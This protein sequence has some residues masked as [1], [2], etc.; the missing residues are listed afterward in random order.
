MFH[1]DTYYIK[2]DFV[3]RIRMTNK[4]NNNIPINIL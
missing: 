2:D 3:I 1:A 4:N